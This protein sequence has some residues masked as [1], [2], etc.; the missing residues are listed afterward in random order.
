MPVW[1]IVKPIVYVKEHSACCRHGNTYYHTY[2]RAVHQ[3]SP[4]SVWRQEP[5]VEDCED[6]DGPHFSHLFRSE[7][8]C[9][10]LHLSRFLCDK[11]M[12]GH[13]VKLILALVP[14]CSG[15]RSRGTGRW[16]VVNITWRTS[17]SYELWFFTWQ[18]LAS[19][20]EAASSPQKERAN[21]GDKIKRSTKGTEAKIDM[22]TRIVDLSV[23]IF[24]QP[25]S[26]S[27][28]HRLY[29]PCAVLS[30]CTRYFRG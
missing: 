29:H 26:G 22:P 27:R 30:S 25:G 3:T 10:F 24:R 23:I 21:K 13:G 6:N 4:A 9:V 11:M 1:H 17:T 18:Q 19:R 7:E 28:Y 16:W 5:R 20:M 8:F 15:H 2:T 14:A 12:G